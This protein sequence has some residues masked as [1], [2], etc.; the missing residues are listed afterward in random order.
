M[1]LQYG[2]APVALGVVAGRVKEGDSDH[3]DRRGDRQWG[4]PPAGEIRN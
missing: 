1:I 4:D 3:G 2:N